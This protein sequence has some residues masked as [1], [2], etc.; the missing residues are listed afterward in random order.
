MQYGPVTYQSNL[1]ALGAAI[2]AYAEVYTKKDLPAILVDQGAKLSCNALGEGAQGLFQESAATAPSIE[3][4]EALPQAQ[5]WRIKRRDKKTGVV[6]PIFTEGYYRIARTRGK[7]AGERFVNKK[8]QFYGKLVG[9]EG[10]I[11][12]RER[13]RLFQ[14][15]GWLSPRLGKYASGVA[16]A[17]GQKNDRAIVTLVLTGPVLSV[18]ITNTSPAALEVA[19]RTGYLTRAVVNRINDLIL[20]T[21]RKWAELVAQLS[22]LALPAPR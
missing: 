14:A 18:E 5:N 1:P 20:Y 11:P 8:G 4:L 6:R 2:V 13:A 19:E 22:S 9:V 12:R 3:L 17:A 16:S 21:E 15:A 7:R 10:V